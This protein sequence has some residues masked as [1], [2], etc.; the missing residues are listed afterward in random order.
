MSKIKQVLMKRDGMSSAI[1]AIAATVGYA[2]NI[3][4]NGV[5]K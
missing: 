5:T 2:Q 4:T 3:A 1:C